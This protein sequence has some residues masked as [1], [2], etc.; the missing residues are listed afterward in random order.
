MVLEVREVLAEQYLGWGER[1]WTKITILKLQILFK[2]LG[3]LMERLLKLSIASYAT[4]K[5]KKMLQNLQF[6]KL[7]WKDYLMPIN[8]YY[9]ALLLGD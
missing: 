8:K 7:T 3:V 9:Y 1:I 5:Q 4:Y 6:I 2:I